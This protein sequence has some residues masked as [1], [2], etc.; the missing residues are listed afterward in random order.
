MDSQ[1]KLVEKLV[2]KFKE[3]IVFEEEHGT[4]FVEKDTFFDVMTQL[5]EKYGFNYLV[6]VTAVDYDEEIVAVYHLMVLP[7]CNKIKVKVKLDKQNPTISSISSLWAA[8]DVQERETYDLIGVI[9]EGHPH[10]KRILCPDDFEG[11]PLR[12]DYKVEARR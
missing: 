6:D 12:K 2:K 7:D 11:H 3:K 5:K 9:Y 4:L 1:I 8:A 10:L